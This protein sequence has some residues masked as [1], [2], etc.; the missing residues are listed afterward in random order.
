MAFLAP[1]GEAALEGAAAEVEELARDAAAAAAVAISNWFSSPKK[2]SHPTQ[3]DDAPNRAPSR[4]YFKKFR[5]T[6]SPSYRR[7]RSN[8]SSSI[9]RGRARQ[10]L[11]RRTQAYWR[12]LRRRR[13]R[14]TLYRRYPGRYTRGT[15]GWKT[16][17]YKK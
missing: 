8:L 7:R 11:R 15:L 10:T 16:V 3:M 5:P 13:N 14:R 1:L 9:T 12:R 6:S 17:S 2:N 4:R